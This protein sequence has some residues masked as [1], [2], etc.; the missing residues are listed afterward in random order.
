MR[1]IDTMVQE[2]IIKPNEFDNAIHEITRSNHGSHYN[3]V[4]SD[5]KALRDMYPQ[6]IRQ[7]LEVNN[8]IV[9]FLSFYETTDKVRNVLSKNKVDV[10]RYEN[11]EESLMII[12]AARAYFGASIDIISFLNSLSKLANKTGKNGLSVFADMGAFFY[13]NKLNHLIRYESSLLSFS[14]PRIKVKAFC[15]YNKSNY[16]ALTIKQKEKLQEYHGKE[17]TMIVK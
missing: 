5:L 11:T 13:Y 16:D 8:N 17:L 14:K 9:L 10:K 12:D 6:L 1:D 7:H 4:Y 2:I 3:V 15:L